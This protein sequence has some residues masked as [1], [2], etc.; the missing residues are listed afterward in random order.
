MFNLVSFCKYA[1]EAAEF[2]RD[3]HNYCQLTYLPRD[4]VY[5]HYNVRFVLNEDT[6]CGIVKMF[7]RRFIKISYSLYSIFFHPKFICSN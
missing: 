7:G 1:I 5:A 4:S 3:S 2:P 6:A